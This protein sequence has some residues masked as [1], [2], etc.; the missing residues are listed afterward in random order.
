LDATGDDKGL[1]EEASGTARMRKEGKK[2]RRKAGVGRAKR[3]N[4][5]DREKMEG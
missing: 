2:E 5:M 1:E 3:W 4:G